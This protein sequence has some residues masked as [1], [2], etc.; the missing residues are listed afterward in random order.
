M[1]NSITDLP[2]RVCPAC[3]GIWFR[4]ATL[5]AFGR[6]P[7]GAAPEPVS[8]MPM[9]VLICLCGTPFRPPIGGLRGGRTP[10][11]ELSQFL[12]N[13]NRAEGYQKSCHDLSRHAQQAAQHFA[14]REGLQQVWIRAA[15][16]E[17][18]IGRVLASRGARSRH[19][20]HWRM[21]KR[22]ACTKSKGRDWL[23]V[24]VQKCG[25]TFD[26]ARAVVGALFDAV[27]QRLQAGESV[28]TPLGEF[29]VEPRG[30]PYF[31][32]RWGKLQK[33]NRKAKRVVFHP[34]RS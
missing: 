31:R 16:V 29:F 14:T 4:E 24:A 2:V 33:M 11:L 19:G 6:G 7:Y 28:A 18:Q 17:Q 21:P 22:Q 34:A 1:Q 32:I 8:R 10:N 5:N 3:Q 23:A 13:L 25:L 30:E 9:T 20:R 12:Q 15:N 26:E 27:T